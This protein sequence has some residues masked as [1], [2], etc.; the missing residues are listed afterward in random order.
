MTMIVNKLFITSAIFC[1][2]IMLTA[3]HA[4][5]APVPVN[6]LDQ[7]II[8]L[9]DVDREMLVEELEKLRGQ[10][11]Q[12]KQVL[13]R[14]VAENEQDGGDAIIAVLV[15]G[16]L[17]YAGYKKIRHDQAKNELDSLSADIEEFSGDLLAMQPVPM[18]MAVAQLP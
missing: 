6:I 1:A 17:L 13:E 12:R 9:P 7:F 15:P 4:D 18:P 3:V 16:G 10:L 14:I 11:M 2:A 8:Q 5:Q